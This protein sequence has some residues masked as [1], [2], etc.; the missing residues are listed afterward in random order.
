M[1][2]RLILFA[3][4]FSSFMLES[5][6]AKMRSPQDRPNV[7]IIYLDDSGYADYAFSGNKEI[8]TPQLDKMAD[9]GF[10]LTNFHSGSPACSASRYALMT[11][12]SPARSGFDSW[13]LYPT[14]KSHIKPQ[15]K[16]LA[17]TMK[18]AAY[19]TTLIGK[20]HLGVP[21]PANNMTEDA[22]PA[23][24][25]FDS[26]YGIPYSNDMQPSLL[27]EQPGKSQDFSS[28][29]VVE[30]PVDQDTLTQRYFER[31]CQYVKK[32][33]ETPFFMYLA[34]S[35]PHVPLHVS[36][37]FKGKSKTKRLYDD[38]IMEIDYCIGKL[39]ATLDK[40]GLSENT[41]VIFS[42]DNGPWLI[43]GSEAGCALPYRDG[44]A[45]TFE[46]GTRVATL[47]RWKGTI[48]PGKDNTLTSVLD[49]HPTLARL[50]HQEIEP[51]GQLDGRDI[52]P[53]FTEA[54]RRSHHQLDEYMLVMAGKMKNIPQS[55]HYKQWKAHFD[56][57][58]QL[59]N[60][61]TKLPHNSPKIS[62]NAEHP[63]LYD[64]SQ[65]VAESVNLAET[66]T[67]V[68]AKLKN[69]FLEFKKSLAQDAQLHQATEKIALSSKK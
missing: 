54:G 11:G 60:H 32:H 68:V 52:S 59:W 25:G 33:K 56:M 44:K 3:L 53:L 20:W 15:E 48:E 67:E 38:V 27:L 64:L 46:G 10:Y 51:Y 57:Y 35:M 19:H 8:E 39:L 23:A 63:A 16:T 14:G 13:V 34:P 55:V 37:M 5:A 29:Q 31:A 47:M 58:S 43:Q 30:R 69:K 2:I 17:E 62:I 21:S 45:S 9:E 36:P 61:Q 6:E 4:V 42:S 7:I 22:L 41:L 28:A 40:E 24:H 12:K 1:N 65:D 50:I 66:H 18:K 49:I 26:Y